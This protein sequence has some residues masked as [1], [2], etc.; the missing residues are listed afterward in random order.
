[1]IASAV[2]DIVILEGYVNGTFVSPL[3]SRKTTFREEIPKDIIKF[4]THLKTKIKQTD[5]FDDVNMIVQ[6]I[7]VFPLQL[8]QDL[9]CTS[10][11][12]MTEAAKSRI[13]FFHN[14]GEFDQI[15]YLFL[16]LT[17]FVRPNLLNPGV[18]Q[19]I[20][21]SFRWM[22]EYPESLIRTLVVPH[23]P[24]M[25]NDILIPTQIEADKLLDELIADLSGKEKK[26]VS[27][28]TGIRKENGEKMA[29][30]AFE[31]FEK[32]MTTGSPQELL[33]DIKKILNI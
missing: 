11:Q 28:L 25:A 2:D 27:T 3:T 4:F 22:N 13:S 10:K 7:C 16:R 24:T 21:N 19:V 9:V 17:S 12:E 6:A 18:A 26:L 14:L 29:K 31:G 23:F 15:T 20:K 8:M 5:N 33:E 30:K 1:M 32:F